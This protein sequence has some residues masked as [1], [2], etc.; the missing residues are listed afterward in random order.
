MR[1][2]RALAAAI[3]ASLPAVHAEAAESAAQIV[4]VEGRGEYRE[5]AETAWHRAAIKQPL[6]ATNFVRTLD[7]SKMDIVFSDRT[8]LSLAPNS[9]LQIKEAGSRTVVN[10]NRGKSWT[11]SKTTPNG[12]TMETPSALA[13][14]RGT[15]WEMVVDD[16][17]TATLSVFSGEVELYNEQG[18]VRVGPREQARAEKGRAPVKLTLQVSRD[19]IQ[20]VSASTIAASRHPGETLAEAYARVKRTSAP[21]AND[22][23]LLGDIEI[24]RG[25]LPAARDAF[26][27]G[28]ARFPGDERFDV[29]LA[30]VAALSDDEAA[31]RRHLASALAR[32]PDSIDALVELGDLERRAGHAQAALGAYERATQL[33][34]RDPRGWHGI[35]VVEAERENLRRAKLNLE[36]AI[37]LDPSDPAARGE[38]AG[39][40]AVRGDFAA[41]RE[42]LAAALQ[43]Q[44][45]NYVALTSAGIVEL[46]AGHAEAAMDALLRA[47]LIEPRYARAH[48]Y[49]AAAY[50][51]SGREHAALEELRRASEMDPKDPLPHVMAGMVHMD[52]LQPV[53]AWNEA[54]EALLRLPYAK[55]LNAVADNQKGVANVGYPLGFMGLEEW[56]RSTAHESY[57]PHWGASHFFLSDRYP[58]DFDRR[59]E[60]MQGFVT[61]PLAFG[62]SN[63]F[64]PLLPAPGHHGTLAVNWS[65]SDDLRATVP[66]VTLNGYEAGRVP[67]AYYVEASQTATQ[68]RN[69]P[70]DL[71][72][73][74]YTVALGAKPTSELGVFLYAQRAQADEDIGHAGVTGEFARVSV[75]GKR[76]DA[77]ARYSPDSRSSVWLKASSSRTDATTDDR[78][79]LVLPEVSVERA[80][81]G[82]PTVR[83][84]D[85]QLR[86]TFDAAPGLQLTW[87]AEG[88]R[89]K[90]TQ[91][92]QREAGFHIPDAIPGTETLD[93]DANDRSEALHADARWDRGPWHMEAGIAWD[94]YRVEHDTQVRLLA[95]PQHFLETFER[96]RFDPMAGVTWRPGERALARAACRRWLRPA[97]LDTFR[98]VAIAG[99]A[100]EDQLVL[101]GGELDQCRAA[102]DWRP[103]S[104][105]FVM[106]AYQHDRVRNVVS[107]LEGPL[108]PNNDV[109]NLDRLRNLALSIP[110][111]ADQLE[112]SPVFAEGTVDRG[113]LSFEHIVGRPLAVRASYTYADA[114][115]TFQDFAGNRIPYVA[116]H[117]A[118]AG[119]TVTPGWHTYLTV[120][121]I[122]RSRRFA[123]EANQVALPAGWDAQFT[124]F[125]ETPDKRW[126]VELRGANLLKKEASDVFFVALS[127]RF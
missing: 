73:P 127:Y 91:S 64:Q 125:A 75:T 42:N 97:S 59:S 54:R 36:R 116:R 101:A 123:D 58:G 37:V 3:I 65:T 104:R 86:H 76:I 110:P 22:A 124:A 9:T 16:H 12:L 99:M 44:P 105:T 63:R 32:H 30:R 40:E 78:V 69:V 62:A 117:L 81:F 51:Q 31:A 102:M 43:R 94:R 68:P 103:G 126:A 17:G 121:G 24:Y 95:G 89:R 52:R 29:A 50:Y 79:T 98:P 111:K 92:I 83:G 4:S 7:V 55:S 48:V 45:D 85:V 10:L 106:A 113:T 41:A 26:A 61:D 56:A 67:F 25:D 82:Q 34:A 8:Q 39:V 15:D 115:S 13:A 71:S 66:V 77:G 100:L 60:L 46:R 74:I 90:S 38:L 33:A 27:R 88:A 47:S 28:A 87:G 72:G 18:R 20:W 5:A 53:D 109:T 120:L 122:Y 2:L 21:G 49:L 1:T 107:P 19:R 6:F 23:L 84:N 70:V 35:G 14:I 114:R 11:Q 118:S 96:K 108:N 93:Q 112:Q 57:D 80:T 119:F